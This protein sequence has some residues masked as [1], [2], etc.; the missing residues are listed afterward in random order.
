MATARTKEVKPETFD[1]KSINWSKHKKRIV[2]VQF[3]HTMNGRTTNYTLDTLK[4]GMYTNVDKAVEEMISYL[5][6]N[7]PGASGLVFS[8]Y[9]NYIL[10][11][12]KMQE[13]DQQF[14]TRIL[15]DQR[16]KWAEAK[17]LWD[18]AERI[19]KEEMATYEKIKKKYNL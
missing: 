14:K 11:K 3:S 6:K 7:Y 8:V 12:G 10:V 4:E 16:S 5:E 18:N 19:K 1:P 15:N 2:N 9:Y 13:T 17:Y